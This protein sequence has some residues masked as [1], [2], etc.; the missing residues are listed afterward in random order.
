M[1]SFRN[2]RETVRFAACHLDL[3][4]L[5]SSIGANMLSQA[6]FA[7][8]SSVR[9]RSRCKSLM[10]LCSIAC[11]TC[12]HE[13]KPPARRPCVHNECGSI[14]LYFYSD[15]NLDIETSVMHKGVHDAIWHSGADPVRNSENL[16]IFFNLRMPLKVS[17]VLC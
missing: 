1:C 7:L 8:R 11:F 13:A 4:L 9:I 2:T 14:F 3:E 6:S 17:S 15:G 10:P 16:F 5:A 12:L